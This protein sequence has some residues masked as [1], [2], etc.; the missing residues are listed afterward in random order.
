MC[1]ECFPLTGARQV[2]R[3]FNKNILTLMLY[4]IIA[5]AVCWVFFFHLR[6]L[7]YQNHKLSGQEPPV[8]D[9][10]AL[11]YTIKYSGVLRVG[12]LMLFTQVIASCN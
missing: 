7:T 11:C 10:F 3:Q 2:A 1:A 5:I 12:P 6:S 4:F 9:V 8:T